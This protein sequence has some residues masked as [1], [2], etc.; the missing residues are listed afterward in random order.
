[1]ATA[2]P[3]APAQAVCVPWD[4]EISPSSG[5]PGTNVTVHGYKFAADKL[6][7]IR[8]DGTLIAT[9]WTD[10]QGGF[11]FI[12]TVPEGCN[13]YYQVLADV[14]YTEVET[15]FTVKPGLIISPEKGP[16]GT[17]VA[18]KGLGFAKNEGGIE[19]MYYSGDTYE[20]IEERIVANA[21]GS[22]ETSFQIPP[23]NRGEHKIDAEGAE[24]KPYKVK[25][26]IFRVT[27]EISL[28]KSSSSVGDTITMTGSRFAVNE[29]NIKILLGGEVVVTGIKANSKGEWQASFQVPEMLAGNYSVSAEGEQTKNEDIIALS[30]EIEPD[31]VLSPIEGHAGMDV[32]V[33][34]R[35]FA[36]S[37]DVDIMFD[38]SVIATAETDENGNFQTSFVVPESQHGERVVAAGYNGENHANA[39][40]TMES[41]P[42]DTP[43]LISP[44]GGSRFGLIGSAMP[45]F[46]WSEVSDDSGVYYSLQI[47]TTDN[48]TASSVIVSV[49]GL[50]ETSYALE[51][52]DA[53]P[54]GSYYWRVQAVDGAENGSDWT[55]AGSFRAGLLPLWGFVLAITAAVVLLVL[56]IR[57][58]VRRRA[59]YYDRW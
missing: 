3:N 23:S 6:V 21:T 20:T 50:A 42:P 15:Y 29:K 5:L 9:G 4:I 10:S 38:G 32:T 1:M 57:A 12:F 13:G 22:W 59:I 7:D 49:T 37:E 18:V 41:D 46:E 47:A 36:A 56:L 35:G 16:V 19:L 34:G 44:S 52:K 25:E 11:T 53:L 55:V 43:D 45:T 51:K 28:D 33:S 30:F 2:L 31:I 54:N 39:I 48:F 27:A 58:L 26:A 8:Y 24:T 17:T 40:F 14:G